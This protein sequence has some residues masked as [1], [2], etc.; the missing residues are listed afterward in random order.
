[1]KWGAGAGPFHVLGW[2]AW[3]PSFP[4]S[5]SPIL[6]GDREYIRPRRREFVMWQGVVDSRFLGNDGR[7]E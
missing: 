2:L 7:W 6:I 3:F 1:M 4:R 5:L